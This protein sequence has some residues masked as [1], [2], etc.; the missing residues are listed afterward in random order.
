MEKQCTQCL[1]T[2]SIYD[3]YIRKG[4]D[5][6]DRNIYCKICARKYDRARYYRSRK[7]R[8]AKDKKYYLEHKEK[9]AEK[10]RL[11][12]LKYP[13]KHQARSK[14]RYAIYTGKIK[15]LP[16]EICGKTKRIQAHHH[17]YS[18][19]YDVKWLCSVHHGEAHRKYKVK[20]FRL[21]K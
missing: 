2:K 13:E 7:K 21:K 6:Y 8:L 12:L 3:F 18:K 5:E 14:L 9:W 4:T 16:C 19:P 10:Q 11:S 20:L 1:E 15:R 17:D